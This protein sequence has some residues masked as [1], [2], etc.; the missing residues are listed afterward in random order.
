MCP[1]F[2]NKSLAML[3]E[4]VYIKLGLKAKTIKKNTVNIKTPRHQ[5]LDTTVVYTTLEIEEIN[6]STTTIGGVT[7]FP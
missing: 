6:E 1:E 5:C 2:Q 7:L 3:G 4:S